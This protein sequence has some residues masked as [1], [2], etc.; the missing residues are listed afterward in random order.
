MSITYTYQFRSA[1]GSILRFF[2]GG[3]SSLT[4]TDR[5]VMAL[6]PTE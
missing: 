5:T 6:Q 4:L 2:G 1:F 3:A